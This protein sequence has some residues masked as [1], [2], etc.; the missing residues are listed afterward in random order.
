MRF[1]SFS[2]RTSLTT[3]E[4]EEDGE[5]EGQLGRSLVLDE[6]EEAAKGIGIARQ[7]T[8]Y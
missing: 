2:R 1:A 8:S 3:E 4:A 5:E 6:G 7:L